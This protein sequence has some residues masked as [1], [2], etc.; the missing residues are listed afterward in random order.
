[1]QSGG[2]AFGNAGLLSSGYCGASIVCCNIDID[3]DG[4]RLTESIMWD[5][6]SSVRYSSSSYRY[7]LLV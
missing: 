3:L 4:V 7:L 5:L 1:M 2:M 6:Q